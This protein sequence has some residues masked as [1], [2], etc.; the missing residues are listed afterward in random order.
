LFI[1]AFTNKEA[2]NV[3]TNHFT[4]GSA[5]MAERTLQVALHYLNQIR[6]AIELAVLLDDPVAVDAQERIVSDARDSLLTR[7]N[8][9]LLLVPPELDRLFKH[10]AM[11]LI[12]PGVRRR[13]IDSTVGVELFCQPPNSGETD[14]PNRA[15]YSYK[16]NRDVD[17]FAISQM[18]GVQLYALFLSDIIESASNDLSYKTALDF[19]HDVAEKVIALMYA[20][21]V[22]WRVYH[23]EEGRQDGENEPPAQHFDLGGG[24]GDP[25]GGG[26]GVPRIPLTPQLIGGAENE[27]PRCKIE[28][29]LVASRV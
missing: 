26:S 19:D 13:F 6:G 15:R 21:K 28:V 25:D 24:F 20:L 4:G 23:S 27:I 5:Q 22:A 16:F 2:Y 7:L 12:A 10:S 11:L 8:A 17:C 29:N 1:S 3:R 18:S 14:N 9:S